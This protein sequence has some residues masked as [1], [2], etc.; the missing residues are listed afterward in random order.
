[1]FLAQVVVDIPARE[2]ERPFSYLIPDELIGDVH[3][4][5]CV[6]VDFANRPAVA[7]VVGL[8]DDSP[9]GFDADKLKPVQAVLGGPYFSEASARVAAWIASEYLA[10]LSESVRLF[11]PPGG[12]PRAVRVE[13]EDG[14]SV[15]S[16]KRP[17]VGPVDDRWVS[18]TPS[19]PGHEPRANATMQKAI[20]S[21][22]SAGPLHVAELAADLG[23]V[24]SAI[25][26]LSEVGVVRIEYRRR[27]RALRT[28]RVSASIA[29]RDLTDGQSRALDSIRSARTSGHGVVVLDGITGSGKTEVYLQAI[30]DVIEAGESALVLVPEIALTPQ[31]VGRFRSRFGDSIAVLHSRLSPGERFDQWDRIA[32]GEVS[33]VVGAR[34]ALFAP[35]EE[36]GLIVID[37]EHEPSYKQSSSPRYHARDVAVRI[38]REVGA[39][40][41]LGSATP[42]LETL[43][44]CEAGEWVRVEMPERA[45]GASLPD[46]TVVDMTAEFDAGHRSMF[47]RPLIAALEEVVARSEQAVLFLNRRGFASFLLC[48]ECG[49]VPM[50][51]SCSTSMTYHEHGGM[52]QCHHCGATRTVPPTCPE[53]ESPY[54]RKFGTGTQRVET[55]IA[56]LFPDVPIV[57]MDADTT[58]G[59]GAHERL[60]ARFSDTKPGILLG[61]QMI[62][63]GLDFPDVTLVGVINADTTLGLPD[64][65][66]GERS[67][68]LLEQVAGRSGRADKP[69]RVVIQTYWPDH[70]S[71]RAVAAHD[72]ALFRDSEIEERRELGYPPY[73]RL[74]NILIRGERE[75][76]VIS[77]AHAAADALR[78]VLPSDHTVLGP[79]AAVLARLQR[80]HRWHVLVKAP[81]DADLPGVVAGALAGLQRTE[82]VAVVVDI[83]PV[84][85]F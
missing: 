55:E 77:V 68:Q 83:D 41:V 71:I 67:W 37:E 52:L 84:N 24:D 27:D 58:K 26:A 45:T 78:E 63:K 50:C 32:S 73:G 62:A 25:K 33:V 17:D 46:V 48:R 72:A 14:A 56:T 47:S 42:S 80:V 10:P 39:T 6:L 82:G 9:E 51:E 29:R 21:A 49:H 60:L 81:R 76:A 20:L 30:Q 57:R 3:V 22:L 16:L 66:A 28:G 18:L 69:G 44:M 23:S 31:T 70:P 74:A 19:A 7:Y 65:R 36:I 15:W 4:G 11:T 54:L 1:M 43:A 85:L 38:A 59:K 13:A 2:L 12:T 40:L 79:S 8:G 5:S 75:D 61:T 34:S 35:L 64:F 53:C